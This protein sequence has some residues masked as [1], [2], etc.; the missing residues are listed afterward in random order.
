MRLSRSD[1][2]LLSAVDRNV[3]D[4][5]SRETIDKLNRAMELFVARHVIRLHYVEHDGAGQGPVSMSQLLSWLNDARR[6]G[7][8]I[9][10]GVITLY[11]TERRDRRAALYFP[12][13]VEYTKE[14]L[15]EPAYVRGQKKSDVFR[16]AFE[17]PEWLRWA[18]PVMA[19]KYLER[20]YD[21]NLLRTQ[22]ALA[23]VEAIRRMRKLE[24]GFAKINHRIV[25]GAD[26][27]TIA[28]DLNRFLEEIRD[29]I[30]S[31]PCEQAM[32]EEEVTLLE[33][34]REKM[35]AL[36]YRE[37]VRVPELAAPGFFLPQPL[38]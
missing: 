9:R 7:N 24:E 14:K 23:T 30:S 3:L 25:G 17:N 2:W 34:Y 19:Q 13:F 22:Y 4:E 10:N 38:E 6:D 16:A 11:F 27:G 26:V 20:L 1:E 37:N 28:D 12:E 32:T 29:F 35:Q 33:K 36:I 8:I 21:E 15:S 31:G 5:I 18:L